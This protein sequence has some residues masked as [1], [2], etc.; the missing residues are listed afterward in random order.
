MIASTIA[1]ICPI[2]G[3]LFR[4]RICL[5]IS[6]IITLVLPFFF[7]YSNIINAAAI[8]PFDFLGALWN[9]RHP[10]IT[11]IPNHAIRTF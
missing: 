3:A 6:A 1:I 10:N 2:H 7:I 4:Y 9:G 11:D 8:I 5:K